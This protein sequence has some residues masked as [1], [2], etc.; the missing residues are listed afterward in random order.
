MAPGVVFCKSQV[1]SRRCR[2]Y[3]HGIR[4]GVVIVERHFL[5]VESHLEHTKTEILILVRCIPDILDRGAVIESHDSCIW[6]NERPGL[7]DSKFG[8]LITF[9]LCRDWGES[10]L[11][12]LRRQDR[13]LVRHPL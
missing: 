5:E 4:D 11:P 10:S 13:C 8:D 12:D 7:L 9:E 3:D 2:I 1:V 6:R